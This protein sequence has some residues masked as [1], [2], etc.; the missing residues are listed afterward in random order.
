[1]TNNNTW[2]IEITFSENFAL[3]PLSTEDGC[4]ASWTSFAALS[5]LLAGAAHDSPKD[6]ACD[7]TFI[8]VTHVPSGE[9]YHARM[10][11]RHPE[12][13]PESSN[14][15]ADFR[16]NLRWNLDNPDVLAGLIGKAKAETKVAESRTWL[17]R[18]ADAQ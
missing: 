16:A 3:N 18:F 2:K 7:K 5:A 10:E 8:R 1:M 6:G 15:L 9:Q 4:G 12:Y 13:S 11:L 17:I 14:V